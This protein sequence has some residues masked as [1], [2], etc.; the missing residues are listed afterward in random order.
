[1]LYFNEREVEQKERMI[2]RMDTMATKHRDTHIEV[3]DKQF[4]NEYGYDGKSV[5]FSSS[6]CSVFEQVHSRRI[7]VLVL[8]PLVVTTIT[9]SL[10][11]NLRYPTMFLLLVDQVL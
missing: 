10:T 5:F 11:H 9:T 3:F 7:Q 1:M 8:L 4:R 2:E 6:R